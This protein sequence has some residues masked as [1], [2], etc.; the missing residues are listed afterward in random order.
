MFFFRLCSRRPKSTKKNWSDMPSFCW[1]TLITPTRGSEE[2]QTNTSLV[3]LRRGSLFFNPQLTIFLPDSQM[4][5][6]R[7]CSNTR[8][9][10]LLWSGRVLK[11][12]L[13][14]LQT[15]S[16]SLS[17]VRK[18]NVFDLTPDCNTKVKEN[19]F[20]IMEILCCFYRISTKI[21]RTMIFQTLPTESPFLTLMKPER[22]V[23]PRTTR[24][25]Q[26]L[27]FILKSS[28]AEFCDLLK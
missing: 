9:P 4:F 7:W 1:S 8:F 15:L 23:I 3:W 5:K 24:W 16:L 27:L 10:H 21:S 2:W 13:D 18:T 11:T 28:D 17:A 22:W 12:M 26:S 6:W 25:Q 14:I 19:N 20:V